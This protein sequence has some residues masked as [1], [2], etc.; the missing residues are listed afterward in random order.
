MNKSS[1]WP[2]Q[3]V[4]NDRWIIDGSSTICAVINNT[5]DGSC[6]TILDG[7]KVDVFARRFSNSQVNEEFLHYILNSICGGDL[8]KMMEWLRQT[9]ED[10][11]DE[12]RVIYSL[13]KVAG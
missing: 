11:T 7:R 1:I 9:T 13:G 12:H 4:S 8:K 3:P 6:V 5:F 10:E 2:I